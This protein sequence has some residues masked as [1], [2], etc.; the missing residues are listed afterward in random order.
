MPGHTCSHRIYST[1]STRSKPSA[2]GEL[3]LTDALAGLITERKLG[4][5]PLSYWMDVGYPWDMLDANA[6]LLDQITGG[7]FR[8]H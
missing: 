4:A 1:G 6:T 8:N 7:K 2:R 5:Y 3:E